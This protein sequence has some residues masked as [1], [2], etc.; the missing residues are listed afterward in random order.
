MSELLLS[1]YSPKLICPILGAVNIPFLYHH[2]P[3]PR[4]LTWGVICKG[5][6][7]ILVKSIEMHYYPPSCLASHGS[8]PCT[9]RINVHNLVIRSYMTATSQQENSGSRSRIKF[10]IRRPHCGQNATE[11]LCQDDLRL[12]LRDKKK[13]HGQERPY[14]GEDQ[15]KNRF[16]ELPHLVSKPPYPRY[17][18]QEKVREVESEIY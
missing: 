15:E 6:K 2:P 18:D 9:L 10:E 7:S 17:A 1:L 4:P 8:L 3:V 14:S 16:G 13:Q 12:L 11:S 5:D